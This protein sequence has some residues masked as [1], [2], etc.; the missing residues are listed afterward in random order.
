VF[1]DFFDTWS[2]GNH[3]QGDDSEA[4][5]CEQSDE[6]TFQHQTTP[7]CREPWLGRV[8]FTTSTQLESK[9][10]EPLGYVRQFED[11]LPAGLPQTL[12]TLV[13][14]RFRRN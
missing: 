9:K 1:C 11:R 4:C 12:N 2:P 5:R 6:E 7:G 14:D 13:R 10:A 8:G 3:A